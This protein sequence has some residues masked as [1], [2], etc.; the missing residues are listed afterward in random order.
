MGPRSDN[1]GYVKE[2]LFRKP[3]RRKRDINLCIGRLLS[4][5]MS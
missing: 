5:T 1:R 2:A 4:P 3:L